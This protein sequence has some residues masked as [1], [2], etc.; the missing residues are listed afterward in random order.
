MKSKIVVVLMFV[1]VFTGCA[2]TRWEETKISET[3]AVSVSLQQQIKDD[4]PVAANYSH[5][6]ADIDS[7]LLKQF[8]NDLVYIGR[9]A[10]LGR[11][12]RH[13]VFQQEEIE[14]LAPAVAK[15]LKKADSN[16]RVYFTSFNYSSDSLLKKRRI[17]E[18]A[19]FLDENGKLNIAFSW[20]NQRVDINDKPILRDE[21]VSRDPF[22]TDDT[23]NKLAADKSY[24]QKADLKGGKEAPMW[25][26]AD[27]S[28]MARAE[29]K[30]VPEEVSGKDKEKD[31]ARPESKE[32]PADDTKEQRNEIRSRLEYL[33]QL[34]QDGLITESEYEAQKKEAL[35]QLQ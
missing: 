8:F 11:K 32:K 9:S 27:L 24:M 17:T 33:K 26:R 20:I 29:K 16:S 31:V 19:I 22:E 28:A 10:I 7:A 34:Y 21:A 15:A 5:P 2:S 18:G 14:K 30:A 25:I 35:E 3:D 6:A 12:E 13:P 23:V 4:A 1:F